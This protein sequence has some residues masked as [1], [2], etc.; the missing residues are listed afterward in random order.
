MVPFVVPFVV[1]SAF[2]RG[3]GREASAPVCRVRHS[4]FTFPILPIISLYSTRFT[5][6]TSPREAQ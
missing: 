1:S 2:Y 3:A 4:A 5:M 6:L